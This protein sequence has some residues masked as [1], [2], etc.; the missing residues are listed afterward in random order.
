[1]T[2]AS[3]DEKYL[4]KETAQLLGVPWTEPTLTREFWKLDD[5]STI[6]SLRWQ[7]GD[8]EIVMLHGGGQNAHTWDAV[9][10]VLNRP[11]VAIDLPGHGHS[12][13]RED[14]EYWPFTGAESIATVLDRMGLS[15]VALV[16][17][18]MGGLTA[19][20]LAAIRPAMFSRV[21]IID[22]T[23]SQMDQMKKMTLEERGTTALTQGPDRYES[24]QAMIDA[25]TALAPTRPA[26]LIERGVVHNSQQFDDGQWGWRYDSM[27]RPDGEDPS[28]FLNDDFLA[29]WHEVNG[30]E[31]PI[32]LVRGGA[33]AFVTEEHVAEFRSRAKDF[34]FAIVDGAGHSVQSDRPAELAALLTEYI[35]EN[36]Y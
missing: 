28:E 21:V 27:K 8:P 34:R 11:F 32:M 20:H 10:L 35:E 17:M 22:V 15:N 5:G 23:P 1:M 24:L 6:S 33:S 25:T 2:N 4:L 12:S 16:G 7:E 30:I 19:I 18:S 31:I 36:T 13:W 29:L 3:H 14:K 26:L 9:G